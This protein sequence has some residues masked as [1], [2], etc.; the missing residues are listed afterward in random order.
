MRVIHTGNVDVTGAT[1]EFLEYAPPKHHDWPNVKGIATEL[2]FRNVYDLDIV[3]LN[4]ATSV[5]DEL[6]E[7]ELPLNLCS[8][9]WLPCALTVQGHGSIKVNREAS[10]ICD[11]STGCSQVTL[12]DVELACGDNPRAMG[13]LQV[14]ASAISHASISLFRSSIVGCSSDADGGSIRAFSMANLELHNVIIRNSSSQSKGGA[15]ALVGASMNVTNSAFEHCYGNDMGGCIWMS[16]FERYPNLPMYASARITH[17]NFTGSFSRNSGGGALALE[18]SSSAN[19]T[20]ATF[21]K[22]VAATKGGA[23]QVASGSS[24]NISRCTFQSNSARG[25]GWCLQH[26][27][28]EFC[29]QRQ[30]L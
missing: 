30:H 11:S 3:H 19:V 26:K 8:H 4:N 28:V 17:C 6:D 9:P 23:I 21:H 12:V 1:N 20:S 16:K 25:V 13:P 22:C 24:I 5:N 10:I 14:S 2:A 15:I 18:G 29:I 7:L 27:L